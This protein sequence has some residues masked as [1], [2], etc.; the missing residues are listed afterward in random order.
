MIVVL[1]FAYDTAD[2][3]RQ[4]NSSILCGLLALI[5]WRRRRRIFSYLR[6]AIRIEFVL[7]AHSVRSG[8]RH[9]FLYIFYLAY[10]LVV[11]PVE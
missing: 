9:F 3:R 5:D 2:R 4:G 10:V 6:P 8:R 1:I 11:I 7:T